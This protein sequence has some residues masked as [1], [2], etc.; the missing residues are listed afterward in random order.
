M[1]ANF[2]AVHM[3]TYISLL[4]ILLHHNVEPSAVSKDKSVQQR[5]LDDLKSILVGFAG[6][7]VTLVDP[8]LQ[9][10]KV[11]KWR[12]RAGK[13]FNAALAGYEKLPGGPNVHPVQLKFEKMKLRCGLI[14]H[15][16]WDWDRFLRPLGVIRED[17][18]ML[19][20]EAPGLYKYEIGP[21]A[22]IVDGIDMAEALSREW[23]DQCELRLEETSLRMIL[24][25]LKVLF[26]SPA[27]SILGTVIE[28][29]EEISQLSTH[30]NELRNPLE[31][32]KNEL[33]LSALKKEEFVNLTSNGSIWD[34]NAT[35][36]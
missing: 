4:T 34:V 11:H 1:G 33:G 10:K 12:K 35:G 21:K 6:G 19:E 26:F 7:D 13:N 8:F 18:S 2:P 25:K 9:A 17:F 14:L 22:G 5:R 16:L 32:V 29:M 36:K 28:R 20:R 23:D 30:L 31:S 27:R 24:R 15:D 3:W